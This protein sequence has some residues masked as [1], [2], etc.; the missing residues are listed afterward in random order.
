MPSLQV[1]DT[2]ERPPE[3]TGVEQFFSKL[4]KSY[5]DEADRV[6]IGRIIDEYKNNRQD[7][8]AFE[9][10]QLEL[11]KS[12]ISP[13]KRLELQKSLNEG[14]KLT[15]ERDKALN[16]R[17][18]KGM[19]TEEERQNEYQN[20]INDG[21]PPEEA[22]IY[23]DS[24]PSVK[25]SLERN[26]RMEKAR[27]IRKPPALPENVVEPEQ[28]L[29]KN[30]G[31]KEVNPLTEKEKAIESPK[32]KE[33][34]WPDILPPEKMLPAE[35]VKWENNNEKENSKELKTVE[36]KKN[37]YRNNNSLIKSMTKV[38]D[39]HK[40]PSG[41]GKM[42]VVE[43]ETG[44]IRPLPLLAEKINPETQ[45]YIKNLKQFL[46]GAKEYF[47]ARVTNFDVTSFM[48]QLPSLLNSEDG[49]RLILKQMQQVNELESIHTNALDKAI[50][51]YGRK[52]N[53]IDI[54]RNVDEQVAEREALL[55][56]Q[57]DNVVEGS[58]QLGKIAN[59]PDKYPNAVLMQTKSGGWRAVEKD[60]VAK[61]EAPPFE[62]SK[63]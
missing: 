8:N 9:N 5:K 52:A 47:G 46:K 12:P 50:K 55:L 11:E 23:V 3:P 43:P 45:L 31:G 32:T 34:E 51:H 22:E 10:M 14:R 25:A 24:P 18:A 26:H 53:Y 7:Y 38:N 28:P 2:T 19:K 60:K 56:D 15:I 1:V 16:S 40:L 13:T 41:L 21:Y 63:Y 29:P 27:G 36:T 6:E 30:V 58:K 33:I 48:Q 59:N 37:A 39:T 42:V 61:Y 20:L 35:R 54:S 44:D 4:G 57:I 62:W 49:R 17:V